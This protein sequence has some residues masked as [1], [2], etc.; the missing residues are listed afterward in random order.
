MNERIDDETTAVLS[1]KLDPK[2]RDAR[3]K[4]INDACIRTYPART[5]RMSRESAFWN[6]ASVLVHDISSNEK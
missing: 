3:N 2:A 6:P 1:Q 4:R 5:R